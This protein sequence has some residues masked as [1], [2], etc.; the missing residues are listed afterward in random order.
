MSG[1]KAGKTAKESG[2]IVKQGINFCLWTHV[3][4]RGPGWPA[5]VGDEFALPQETAEEVLTAGCLPGMEGTGLGGFAAAAATAPQ[6]GP[7]EAHGGAAMTLLP[8]NSED[9]SAPFIVAGLCLPR[10]QNWTRGDKM[11]E[12]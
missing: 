3:D 5:G 9:P 7:V 2:K 1:Q 6:A 11:E 12:Y 10:T 8:H 4:G